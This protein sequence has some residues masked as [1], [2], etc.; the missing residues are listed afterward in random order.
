MSNLDDY[1]PEIIGNKAKMLVDLGKCSICGKKMLKITAKMAGNLT[2]LN[3]NLFPHYYVHN[4]RAQMNRAFIVF[5]SNMKDK[6]NNY[7]CEECVKEGKST[8]VCA[9]CGEKRSSDL[10][11]ESFGD[12]P[13]FLCKICYETV[14][15]KI[16][17]EKKEELYNTHR[18]DFD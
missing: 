2:S 3:F 17:E 13:E 12:P 16:W 9:L 10:R 4:L 18:W 1:T 8:F 14:P 7:I 5:Q 11:E 15:A 6:N